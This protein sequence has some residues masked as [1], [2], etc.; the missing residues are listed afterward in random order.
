[1]QTRTLAGEPVWSR[2]TDSPISELQPSGDALLATGA[3]GGVELID[4]KTG[5]PREAAELSSPTAPGTRSPIASLTA[6]V[7]KP[8][9]MPSQMV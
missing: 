5:P 9:A 2:R 6:M 3:R 4:I 7:R 1:M 8:S